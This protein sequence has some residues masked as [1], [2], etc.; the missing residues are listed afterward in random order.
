MNFH[1]FTCK[2]REGRHI[3]LFPERLSYKRGETNAMM[4]KVIMSNGDFTGNV[5]VTE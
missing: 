3:Q 2:P 1:I 5:D 4:S